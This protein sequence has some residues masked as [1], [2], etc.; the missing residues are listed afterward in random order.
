MGV[1]GGGGGYGVVVP[2]RLKARSSQ[3][4]PLHGSLIEC[5]QSFC[6]SGVMENTLFVPVTSVELF[7]PKKPLP[8][9]N[10]NYAH[11]HFS[12]YEQ[13]LFV[14]SGPKRI[15]SLWKRKVEAV[16]MRVQRITSAVIH[17]IRFSLDWAWL[18]LDK[19][20]ATFTK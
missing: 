16:A 8:F 15:Y 2:C 6:D 3:L 10:K 11:T 17:G 19:N 9:T 14:G 1:G 4:L 7:P 13:V 5:C 20:I 12:T 18:C